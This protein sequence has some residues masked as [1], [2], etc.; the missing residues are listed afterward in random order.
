[1]ANGHLFLKQYFDI[2][3]NIIYL[4]IICFL[5]VVVSERGSFVQNNSTVTSFISFSTYEHTFITQFLSPASK[6]N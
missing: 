2:L 6:H 3:R 4:D 1:M 5:A